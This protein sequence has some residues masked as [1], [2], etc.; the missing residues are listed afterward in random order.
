VKQQ[1]GCGGGGAIHVDYGAS[2]VQYLR[3]LLP[4]NVLAG[5]IVYEQFYRHACVGNLDDFNLKV[6]TNSH[7]IIL[8][9]LGSVAAERL[10]NGS[11]ANGSFAEQKHFAPH[12]QRGHKGAHS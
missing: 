7:E 10:T 12:P 2:A 4:K 1:G 11:L 9:K 8:G 3:E 6:A 5:A